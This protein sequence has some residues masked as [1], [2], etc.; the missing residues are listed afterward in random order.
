MS[1]SLESDI[2]DQDHNSSSS[3][4]LATL[5]ESQSHSEFAEPAGRYDDDVPDFQQRHVGE[6]EGKGGDADDGYNG[7]S[8][9]FHESSDLPNRLIPN[10]KS[11]SG[12]EHIVKADSKEHHGEKSK[13]QQF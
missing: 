11:T 2:T 3:S 12:K 8:H 6:K 10:S 1:L 4:G 5:R 13:T 7:Q 9:G